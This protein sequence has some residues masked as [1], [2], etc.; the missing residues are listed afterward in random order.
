MRLSEAILL[1][2]VETAQGF[3][4]DSINSR[5]TPC[6]AGAAL[7]AIGKQTINS[8]TSDIATYWPWTTKT[9]PYPTVVPKGQSENF[10]ISYHTRIH[11]RIWQLNDYSKWSRP[12]IAAWIAD[13]EALYDPSC[14]EQVI[15]QR[16]E[17]TIR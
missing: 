3:G 9:I 1:G 5:T 14:V 4:Y 11:A 2:S 12:R 10:S 8:I 17:V 13:L 16:E 6:A 15:P 7:L